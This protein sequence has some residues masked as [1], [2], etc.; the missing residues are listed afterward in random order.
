MQ[1]PTHATGQPPP[2]KQTTTDAAILPKI[3]TDGAI[4]NFL[5][6][7]YTGGSWAAS[8]PQDGKMPDAT[9]QLNK[10]PKM[11]EL[12]SRVRI[13]NQDYPQYH[14]FNETVVKV[15][16]PYN[17]RWV[18]AA[19]EV[20]G[21][22]RSPFRED[23]WQFVVGKHNKTEFTNKLTEILAEIYP[24]KKDNGVEISMDRHT[25][26]V[27][28][29]A[30]KQEATGVP[31]EKVAEIVVKH[32]LPKINQEVRAKVDAQNAWVVERVTSSEKMVVAE[33]TSLKSRM[34]EIDAKLDKV[35]RPVIIH[36]HEKEQVTT[37]D[38]GVQHKQF[39]EL[40]EVTMALPPQR[41]NIWLAGPAGS[42]KTTATEKM[43]E[44][45]GLEYEYNGAIDT[46]YK[47]SGY[48]NAQGEYVDTAFYRAWT[49]GKV[50][51]FD[52]VDASL[53]G[54]VLAFN[55]ALSGGGIA[56]FP[57]GPR[58]RHPNCVIYACANTWG[59]GG[60]AQYVGRMKQ[61][62]AFLDRFVPIEWEYDEAFE[63]AL[64]NNDD[65]VKVVHKTRQL[66]RENGAEMIVSPRA[67]MAG[68]DLLR[69][70]ISKDR[71]VK[72]IFGRYRSHSKW[73]IVGRYAE[74]FGRG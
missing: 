45:L 7:W 35:L 48:M 69:A 13:T 24:A 46:E 17:E 10:E 55:G 15:Y 42:G 39:A 47:L 11:A 1:V 49:Q 50:Y 71:V 70:G 56:S 19:K 5:G 58:K 61:D 59:L 23:A 52:E 30:P 53:P 43:A 65:W 16:T 38:L 60:T 22:W 4:A 64:A 74:E 12:D 29:T 32:A 3:A 27:T 66:M 73:S 37:H 9:V 25:N 41:R 67:S 40:Y 33:S 68:A 63:S 31:M 8:G 51:T 14:T 18:E 62:L 72:Y 26:G 36:Q 54:A 6:R 20:G 44:A 21:R 28:A 34:A 57:C 2:A